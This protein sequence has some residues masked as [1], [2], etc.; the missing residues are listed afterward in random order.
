MEQTSRA[1]AVLAA[2]ALVL[3]PVTNGVLQ[4]AAKTAERVFLDPADYDRQPPRDPPNATP[5]ED[6]PE[7]NRT[8]NGS[9]GAR[10]S[11]EV[12]TEPVAGWHH[13]PV[14]QEPSS[15]AS[16]RT[17]DPVQQ[18]FEVNDTHLGLG[19]VLQVENLQGDLSASVHPEGDSERG[20]SYQHPA[21]SSQQPEDVNQTSTISGSQLVDGTWVA[22]LQYRSANYDELTFGVVRASCA[23]A[24]S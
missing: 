21:L 23:G 4:E 12:Q 7:G 6:I 11:C 18:T 16:N 2:V 14:G 24:P 22:E 5:P 9:T 20:F 13:E 15:G 1:F 8:F 17:M 10:P 3:A 19:I